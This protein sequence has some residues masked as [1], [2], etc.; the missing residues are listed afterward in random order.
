M[1]AQ[2][3][4]ASAKRELN[5]L[6][7]KIYDTVGHLDLQSRRVLN[8][9]KIFLMA[10]QSRQVL[11]LQRHFCTLAALHQLKLCL[12]RQQHCV[13]YAA[14]FLISMRLL[15]WH[16]VGANAGMQGCAATHLHNCV[17]FLHLIN[18]R[19]LDVFSYMSYI[20]FKFIF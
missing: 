14:G 3:K 4:G 20:G 15:C 2:R 6:Y 8:V 11:I 16:S 19:T 5:V 7:P 1:P 12:D 17:V 9:Q 13:K 10:S 18:I